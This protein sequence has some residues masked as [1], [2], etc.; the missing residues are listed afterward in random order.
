MRTQNKQSAG[1]T[2]MST[3][4]KESEGEEKKEEE[5]VA[6]TE[7]KLTATPVVESKE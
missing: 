1:V 2:E 3:E 7:R 4:P 6:D 5:V